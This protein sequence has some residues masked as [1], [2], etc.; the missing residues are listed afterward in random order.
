MVLLHIILVVVLIIVSGVRPD[1]TR[2]SQ[3]ELRRRTKAGDVEAAQVLDRESKMEDIFSLQRAAVA[4]LLVLVSFVGVAAYFWAWGLVVALI[5]ALEAGAV[6]RLRPVQRLAARAY[7]AVEP[8]ILRAID[9]YPAFFRLIRIAVPVREDGALGSKEELLHLVE[10]SGTVLSDD[11][12]LMVR[13]ALIFQDKPVHQVMVPKSVVQTVNKGEVLGPLV[14]DELHKTGHSRFPVIE[15]D[16]DHVVGVLHI[17]DLMEIKSDSKSAKV[18]TLMEK[19]VYYIDQNKSLEYA[20]AAFLKARHHLFI[21]INSYR[22]TI[23]I[24]TLEDVV[25]AL[26]GKNIVDEFDTYDDLRKVAAKQAHTNN[27]SDATRDV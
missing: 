6:A 12:K 4:F 8:G 27:T 3:F 17:Q 16:I 23:G 25:E 24:L 11:E 9:R 13:N 10:E 15:G 18:D 21:V 19:R 7:A 20:L 2:V 5:L 26:I 14:L 22:E 1:R